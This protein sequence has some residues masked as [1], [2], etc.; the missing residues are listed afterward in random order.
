[1]K[2]IALATVLALAATLASA[3]EVGVT[4]NRDFAGTDRNGYGVTLG[5]QYGKV[6]ATAGFERFTKG[7]ND[8]DRYSLVGGYDVAKLGKTTVTAKAGVAYLQP[9]TGSTGYAALVGA[10]VSYPLTKTVSLTAD[11]RYQVG[12]DRVD[13][14]NGST[15]GAGLKVSF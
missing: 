13:Q 14:Y 10:G 15:V 12:Q 6:N 1:M 5:Q 7:S 2:K 8:L 9:Q 11:Y 4:G 3:V